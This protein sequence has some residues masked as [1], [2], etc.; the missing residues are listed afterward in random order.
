MIKKIKHN[1]IVIYNF[2]THEQ[3]ILYYAA[4]LSFYTIF[5]II[6]LLFIAFSIVS[7]LPSFH[8]KIEDLKHWIFSYIVPTNSEILSNMLDT[9][10]TNTPKM[11]MVG[12]VYIAFTSLFFFRNYEFITSRMFNSKP[13][14]LLDSLTMYWVFITF[15]PIMIAGVFYL[16]N[17]LGALLSNTFSFFLFTKIASWV[18]TYFLFILLFQL[19]ANK[20]LNKKILFLSSFISASVWQFFKWGFISY[21]A[22]NKAYPS[23]YGSISILLISMLW[24][25][26]FWTILLFG[27]RL[28]EGINIATDIKKDTT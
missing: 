9:F 16:I 14:K 15:F 24:I 5:A 18:T 22:Y 19:S 21:I 20:A 12:V 6:P 7:N 17:I 25:Y 1:I 23:L 2:L 28:C 10:I 3:E 8:G 13:R 11:G 26:L 27:M 4:S